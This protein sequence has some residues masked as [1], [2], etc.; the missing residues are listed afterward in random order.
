MFFKKSAKTSEDF[1]PLATNNV[2][3]IYILGENKLALFLAAKLQASGQNVIIL[4]TSAPVNTFKNIEFTLKEE[5]NLKKNT[6]QIAATSLLSH[7]PQLI[8]IASDQYNLQSHLTL[9]PSSFYPDTQ[10]LC[11]NLIES[12]EILR[13]LLGHNYNQ[14]YFNGHLDSDGSALSALGKA[15]QIVVSSNKSE[16]EL[17]TIETIF[18][19][20]EIKVNLSKNDNLNFWENFA[21]YILGYLCSSAKQH[22]VDL[23]NDKE[24]KNSIIAAASE[25]C[26]LAT[27]EQVHLN[28][29]ELLRNLYETPHS[30]YFKKSNTS[31][32]Y[33]A[34]ILD[35]Y[36]SLLSLKARTYKCKTPTLNSLIKTNYNYLLKE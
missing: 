28:K 30:F 3:P 35:S 10:L 12:K 11:F 22:I 25:L 33:E 23:L 16:N 19:T 24:E 29:E 9:L 6:F 31:C 18:K 5:Y 21:P 17:E 36:H 26:R 1:T 8:I 15:P 27:H 13:P 14:A 20:A 34:A 4:T 7:K 2:N 32:T